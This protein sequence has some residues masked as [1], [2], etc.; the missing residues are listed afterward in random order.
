VQPYLWFIGMFLFSFS[1]HV[2]G[3][4]GMPRR[5]FD[6]SY[7]DSPIAAQWKTLTAVSAVGGVFLFISAVFFLLVMLGTVL[8]G[9]PGEPAMI[10][11]AQPLE[12]PPKRG[13][14]DRLGL[15]VALAIVLVLIAYA[16]PL[17]DHLRMPR[18]GSPG[19]SPF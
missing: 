9:R 7:L 4:M 10:V 8:A 18:F 17:I 19:Y 16:F 15:W 14:F 3:L 5:V 1:N 2:T 13:V 11:F 6:P 12:G